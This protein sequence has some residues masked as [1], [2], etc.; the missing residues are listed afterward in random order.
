MTSE[1]LVVA[2][3][4]ALAALDV[5]FMV[6]GSL[7]SNF[8]G[9]PRGTQDA[10]IVLDLK[11]LPVD[12]LAARLE[13]AFE[14]DRQAAFESVLGSPRLLVRAHGQAFE[15]E[16]FGLTDDRHDLERFARRRDVE[17]LGRTVALP[18]VGRRHRQ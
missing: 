1:D 12:A 16:L 4:D 9:V 6:S 7:A 15:V 10:D 2:V 17:V 8:Y 5:P 14:V 3:F 13:D 18:T 11:R